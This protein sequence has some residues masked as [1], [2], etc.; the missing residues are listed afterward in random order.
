MRAQVALSPPRWVGRQR[1]A[2]DVSSEL[3]DDLTI[4]DVRIVVCEVGEMAV[5]ARTMSEVFVP[6]EFYLAGWPGTL[7]VACVPHPALVRPG[8][9]RADRAAATRA[10]LGRGGCA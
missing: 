7:V 2:A 4:C 8:V 10:S 1:R 9:V 3:M 5:S 6:V